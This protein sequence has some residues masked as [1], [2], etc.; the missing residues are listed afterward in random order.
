MTY[1]L[2]WLQNWIA[3]QSHTDNGSSSWK[4]FSE[5]MPNFPNHSVT[6]GPKD[7]NGNFIFSVTGAIVNGTF[8]INKV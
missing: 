6:I 3:Q 1:D 8:T 4:V 5:I 7:N 2:A